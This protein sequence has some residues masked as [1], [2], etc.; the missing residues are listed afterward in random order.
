MLDPHRQS[1][2]SPPSQDPQLPQIHKALSA[3]SGNAHGLSGLGPGNLWGGGNQ[4]FYDEINNSIYDASGFVNAVYVNDCIAT[5]VPQI[6]AKA[7]PLIKT[8]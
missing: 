7:Q 8:F 1:R 3:Q 6:L 4:F 5:K 2:I